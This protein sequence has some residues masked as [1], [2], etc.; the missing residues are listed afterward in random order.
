MEGAIEKMATKNETLS[1]NKQSWDAMADS[2]FGTTALP[3]YGCLTPTEN[4]LHLFPTC[5]AKRMAS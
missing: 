4:E 1:Q 3:A 5:A 2:W